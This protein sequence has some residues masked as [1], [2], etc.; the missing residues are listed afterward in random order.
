MTAL[1]PIRE[2]AIA[3]ESDRPPH[4]TKNQNQLSPTSNPGAPP[5]AQ[6]T[7]H[8]SRAITVEI[9]HPARSSAWNGAGGNRTHVPGP[10]ALAVSRVCTSR[11]R[12]T[13]YQEREDLPYPD[14]GEVQPAS[15]PS[16]P[17]FWIEA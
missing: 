17:A 8:T 10:G 12:R 7:I 13:G 5:R 4:A 6:A 3:C 14:F 2:T 16:G 9:E 15:R 11:P 1:V